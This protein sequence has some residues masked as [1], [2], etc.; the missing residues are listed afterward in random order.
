MSQ[1]FSKQVSAPAVYVSGGAGPNTIRL[2]LGHHG[3][4]PRKIVTALWDEHR[5]GDFL[6]VPIFACEPPRKELCTKQSLAAAY[7][8]G[9][10]D[11]GQVEQLL[12]DFGIIP[13]K[14][15]AA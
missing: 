3:E 6:A 1:H 13:P 8:D 12:K 2:C 11:V 5:N 15:A 4:Y 7:R 10:L 14:R 9:L